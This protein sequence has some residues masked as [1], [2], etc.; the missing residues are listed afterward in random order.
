MFKVSIWLCSS[1]KWC[2]SATI[3][4]VWTKLDSSVCYDLDAWA[5]P[6]LAS[7][8]RKSLCKMDDKSC[9]VTFSKVS[10]IPP[11]HPFS[12][13][14]WLFLIRVRG[15]DG[16][17]STS[18]WAVGNGSMTGRLYPEKNQPDGKADDRDETESVILLLKVDCA[19]LLLRHKWFIKI[20]THLVLNPLSR[21]CVKFSLSLWDWTVSCSIRCSVF[22]PF[23]N[24][25]LRSSEEYAPQ[26]VKHGSY[27]FNQ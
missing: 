22:G 10:D 18:L 6:W 5:L 13:D 8:P 26:C 3:N 15:S 9:L 24:V 12:V 25:Y 7:F 21:S 16:A 11:I 19:N 17:R 27:G 23:L 14:Y 2:Q 4:H 1:S 20:A